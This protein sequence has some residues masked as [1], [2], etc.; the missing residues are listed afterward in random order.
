MTKVVLCIALVLLLGDFAEPLQCY[1][2]EDKDCKVGE[3]SGGVISLEM[4]CSQ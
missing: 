2:F 1:D 3:G 4:G